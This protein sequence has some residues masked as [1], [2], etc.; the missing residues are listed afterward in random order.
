MDNDETRD[1][2]DQ[3]PGGDDTDN[4]DQ[5]ADQG[6]PDPA[7]TGAAEGDEPTEASEPQDKAAGD[8]DES[9]SE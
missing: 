9:D 5:S 8:V 2:Q 1:D 6:A 7:P 3:T 4:G